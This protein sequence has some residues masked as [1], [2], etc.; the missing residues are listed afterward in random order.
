MG[1]HQGPSV[2]VFFAQISAV[3]LASCRQTR[4]GGNQWLCCSGTAYRHTHRARSACAKKE[5]YWLVVPCQMVS[6]IG[7]RF[8]RI[9]RLLFRAHAVP[10]IITGKFSRASIRGA[11]PALS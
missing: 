8:L 11:L 9:V 6:Q 10:P 5:C 7:K 2:Y 1:L 4:H 3:L